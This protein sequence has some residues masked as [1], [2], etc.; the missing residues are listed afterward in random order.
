MK[1]YLFTAA[2]VTLAVPAQAQT[3]VTSNFGGT[4]ATNF[5]QLAADPCYNG[6]YCFTFGPKPVGANGYNVTFTSAVTNSNSPL[7]S[8]IGNGGYGLNANGFW[9]GVWFASTDGGNGFIRFSFTAPVRRFGGFMN[10]APG[11]GPAS[12]IRALDQLNNVIA[13]YDIEALAPISTPGGNN[14]G[15]FRG[16]EFATAEIWSLEIGNSYLLM[17]DM[18]VDGQSVVPEPGTVVLMGTGLLGLVAAARRRAR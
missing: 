5:S 11:S 17:Q 3:L 4:V 8:A 10:Y 6:S 16:I 14:A 13:S 7:G 2:L 9:S 12:T 15:A 1:R 18:V